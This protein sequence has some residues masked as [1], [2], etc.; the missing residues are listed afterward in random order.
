M[1]VRTINASAFSSYDW[2]EYIVSVSLLALL[3]KQLLYPQPNSTPIPP[4]A[5]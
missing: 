2:D 1:V 3:S 5:T 4:Q